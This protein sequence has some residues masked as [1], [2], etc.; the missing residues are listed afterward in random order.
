ML[1]QNPSPSMV[2]P[3]NYQLASSQ[4]FVNMHQTTSP[5]G[6]FIQHSPL[7]QQLGSTSIS[8]PQTCSEQQPQQ[9]AQKSAHFIQVKLSKRFF[10]KTFYSIKEIYIP[11]LPKIGIELASEMSQKYGTK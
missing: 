3:Q 1:L 4:Q 6:Q 9:I 11:I 10:L 8:S 7:I 2:M 5:E